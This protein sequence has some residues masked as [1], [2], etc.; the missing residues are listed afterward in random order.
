MTRP[1][2]ISGPKSGGP[3]GILSIDVQGER[4]LLLPQAAVYWEDRRCLLIADPHFGKGASFRRQGVPVPEGTT[5]SDLERVNRLI[6][7]WSAN[8]LIVLGDFFHGPEGLTPGTR[9]RIRRWRSR[10]PEIV[11]TVVG[12]NHDRRCRSVFKAL[13]LPELVDVL[14]MGPFRLLHETGEADGRYVLAGHLHP[15]LRVSLSPGDRRAFPCFVFGRRR[16][17]LPAF[18]SFTGL[19]SFQPSGADQLFLTVDGRVVAYPGA[20]RSHRGAKG[21]NGP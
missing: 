7:H 19:G 10:L 1:A 20:R 15:G 3:D 6:R 12:G 2:A 17:V 5:A 13:G 18:G 9:D 4:L 16:A 8:R 14:D 21:D 11:L